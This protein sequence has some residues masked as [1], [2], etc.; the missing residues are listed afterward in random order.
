MLGKIIAIEGNYVRLKLEI[1][2]ASQANLVNIH[3]VFEDDKSKIVGEIQDISQTEMKIAIVGELTESAF[4]SGFAKKPS[5]KATTRIVRMEELAL[6]LG[7]QQ[8]KDSSQVYFGV[9]TVYPNYRVNV[10][11]N[12][13]FSH[14]FAV[15]GNTGSGKSFTISKLIQNLFA[16]SS[17]VPVNSNIFIFDAYGEY[18]TAFTKLEEANPLIR[19]K[20]ITTDVESG[21][22]DLLKLPLW[23][24]DVDDFAQ[25]LGV[26]NPS[27]L[28][29]IDKAL[30]LVKVLSSNNPDVHKHKNDI[31][32]RAILDILLS[33]N[34]SGKIRDQIIAILTNFHTNELNLET[35]IAQPGYVRTLKQCL[36]T[37]KTGKMQEMEAVVEVISRF[38]VEDLDLSKYQSQNTV[39]TLQDLENA[40]DFALISEGILKSNHIF[41]Y[42]NILSVRLHSL[43][44]SS[45]AKYFECNEMISKEMYIRKLIT[46]PDGHKAQLVNFN[47]SHVDDR[48]AKAITKIISR[49]LFTFSLDVKE[50]A[51][52]PFH[53][54]IEEAHRY[55]QND[56]DTEILGYNIFDRITKEGRKYG[57]ILGLITQRPSELSETS[58]SQ[59]SN[60]LI[61]RTLHP[62]DLMF[63]K[64]MVPSVGSEM[65][66]QLKSLPPGNCI[67]FG[68]A[69]KVPVPMR[70]EKPNPEPLS[71][72][73][74]IKT[75]W[76]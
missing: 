71:N 65:I 39:F 24:L 41:D 32:A 63:I 57:V 49:I 47:I 33:G 42:A 60:F 44:N 2:I 53:I 67:A 46:A 1:D 51:K 54:I 36:Y 20:V 68:S 29:I 62:K 76:F 28:P 43:A 15:L 35:K 34:D 6:I 48:L 64:N 69:F 59:C 3:V 19:Y 13:F 50:R 74:D 58:I 52:I 9:S 22:G 37:D 8:I 17:Y 26:D 66:E 55:V 72:N 14:H 27:Q 10:D 31:L 23:L 45:A 61:L 30:T 38:I 16:G 40:M 56:K 11:V 21:T 25:L 73:A 7:E 75:A 18:T 4:I 70:F 5:F 12:R